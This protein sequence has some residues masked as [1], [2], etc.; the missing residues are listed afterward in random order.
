MLIAAFNQLKRWSKQSS[1]PL[2]MALSRTYYVLRSVDFPTIP[3]VH[4]MVYFLH[5]Q[6]R[7]GFSFLL[8]VFYWTPLFKSQLST[9][10]NGLYLYGGLPC[11]LG[12]LNIEMGSH[13]RLAAK[14]TI[15]GRTA[16]SEKPLLKIGNNVGIGWR[17]TIS[18]GTKVIIGNNVRISGDSYLAGYPGHPI[19]AN[20]RALGKPDT[21]TQ[22]LPIILE[23]DVWIATGVFVKSGVTIGKGTIVAAG[24]VVTKSLP[25][26]VLAGGNPAKVIRKL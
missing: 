16:T 15:S 2:A 25:S 3:V 7:A 13:C 21:K 26:N 24:S 8:R 12:H 11:L 18:V 19:N 4:S 1:N 20:Q 14:T 9:P 6:V 23:D 5:C 22:V 17:V 10:A